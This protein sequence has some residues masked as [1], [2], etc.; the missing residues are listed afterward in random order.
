MKLLKYLL[1]LAAMPVV[2]LSACSDDDS[3][4][5]NQQ[6]RQIIKVELREDAVLTIIPDQSVDYKLIISS[7]AAIKQAVAYVN[8]VEIESSR[9][10]FDDN[11]LQADYDFGYA[12]KREHT[13]S[14]LNFVV[15]IEG[16]S[17]RVVSAE[18][19]VYVLSKPANISITV[20]VDAPAE[21]TVGK[22]TE[23]DIYVTSELSLRR[24]RT[25]LGGIEIEG[26]TQSEFSDPNS[27]QYA[28]AY[29]PVA[30][31]KGQTLIFTIEVMDGN[32]NIITG[33]YEATAKGAQSTTM[34]EYFG[35]T[36]GYHRNTEYGQFLDAET[37]VVYGVK[38]SGAYDD[39]ID[40]AL[41]FSN[42]GGAGMSLTAPN[43]T[44]A[45][46]IF[47]QAT[48]NVYGGDVSDV[49]TNWPVRNET[50][51]KIA[52]ITPDEFAELS[53]GD[54]VEAVYTNAAG[55]GTG[56]ANKLA[57]N[58]MVAFMTTTGKYGVI[59]VISRDAANN[60]KVVLDYKIQK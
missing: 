20:P 56:L 5:G 38:G 7:E 11:T 4:G 35:V 43:T 23:F 33:S 22:A 29:T 59:K 27:V 32:G 10:V 12:V 54:Q 26:L 47:N 42:S 53:E 6:K 24:I 19:S 25:L 15:K 30:T 18:Y 3:D 2:L 31:D 21:M 58:S 41:F 34:D 8:G 52:T 16:V 28:F 44:N 55:E 57:P 36:M 45:A 40:I 9:V 14:T 50:L 39:I 49:I 13:G 17:G 1:F 51:F 60:G 48:I 46:T 37:G